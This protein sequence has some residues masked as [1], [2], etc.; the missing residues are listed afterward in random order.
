MNAEDVLV[1]L[2]LEHKTF[3]ARWTVEWLAFLRSVLGE[4]VQL[5]LVVVHD[6]LGALRTFYRVLHDLQ[7][8]HIDMFL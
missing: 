3:A 1:H 4:D 6:F 7:V 5:Q 2:V 8:N